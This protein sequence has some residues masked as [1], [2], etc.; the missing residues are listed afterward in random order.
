MKKIVRTGETIVLALALAN[1]PFG[2]GNVNGSGIG[3]YVSFIAADDNVSWPTI[4]AHWADAERDARHI[5]YPATC[6]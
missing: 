4:T 2:I 6:P 3:K 1:V 5:G